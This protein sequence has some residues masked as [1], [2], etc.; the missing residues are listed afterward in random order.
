MTRTEGLVVAIGLG[1]LAINGT[2]LFNQT[3]TDDAVREI[4]GEIREV[5]T[6]QRQ[7]RKDVDQLQQVVLIRTKQQVVLNSKELDCLAKNI[8]HEAGV[9]GRAGKI[10][11]AQVTLNRL[12]EGRWGDTVCKVVYAR[13]QFSWTLDK[14]KRNSQ[15]KG[16]L[17]EQSLAVAK[18]FQKGV[19]VK[20]L[21]DSH[22]YHANWIAKPDWAHTKKV[23]HKVGQ[24]IFYKS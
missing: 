13:A 1:L 24:H 10:A 6:T 3:Q 8:F 17:W 22:H 19:R 23:A 4:Q 15:P 11:V 18:E 7:I 5:Q 2:V 12:N 21:E 9:E 16:E 20:G 14:K